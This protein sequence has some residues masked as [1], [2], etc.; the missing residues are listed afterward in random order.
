MVAET[1]MR[2]MRSAKTLVAV[3]AVVMVI[4]FF[5]IFAARCGGIAEFAAIAASRAPRGQLPP[6]ETWLLRH[7]AIQFLYCFATVTGIS[8]E[9]MR[10]LSRSCTTTRR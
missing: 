5:Q 6:D 7:C 1:S 3:A 2:P 8:V 4:L 10:V 9:P